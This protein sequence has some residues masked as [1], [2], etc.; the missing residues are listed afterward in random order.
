VRAWA[1]S[2]KGVALVALLCGCGARQTEPTLRPYAEQEREAAAAADA[3]RAAEFEQAEAAATRVL[4]AHPDNSLAH[5]VR[6]IARLRA[7]GHDLATSAM[8]LFTSVLASALT[9]WRGFDGRYVHFVLESFG[10]ELETIDADLAGV[11]EQPDFRMQLCLACWE[12]DWN[13]S[14][15]VDARDRAFFAVE[16]DADGKAIA[17]DDPRRRP[18]FHFDVGDA[19]WLR[20]LL[21]FLQAATQVL[22]AYTFDASTLAGG[23]QA[24]QGD[25]L[26]AIDVTLRLEHPERIEK[27]R[28]LVERGIE[29]ARQARS[30]YL[31]ETDDV[32][33]WVP[34]P[35][36]K[37]H[38]IPLP[39][40]AA[41]YATWEAVLTDLA[42]LLAGRTGLSAGELAQ[43]GDD[44]WRTP[45]GGYIDVQGLFARP[46]DLVLR[47]ALLE[48]ATD[49]NDPAVMEQALRE[50]LGDKYRAQMKRSLLLQRLRRMRDEVDRGQ[51]TFERKLRYLLWLN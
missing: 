29:L 10:S 23:M 7:A 22:T 31:A 30:A 20:A 4:T 14:G 49:Q 8:S 12:V 45:P 3:L 13:R 27:A 21:H 5:A 38:P 46:G 44:K 16:L 33:E 47:P 9:G 28:V 25:D 48:R 24:I 39:V 18:T 32:G 2:M 43:L 1:C 11:T 17:E 35:R 36:Q 51:E 42:D 34:N 15:E 41:L 40:D 19:Y 50:V 26:E 6:A 37:H